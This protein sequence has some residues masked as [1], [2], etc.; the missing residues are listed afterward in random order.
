AAFPGAQYVYIVRNDTVRQAVSLAKAIRSGQWER[1]LSSPASFGSAT[2]VASTTTQNQGDPSPYDR[3]LIEWCYRK[4]HDDMRAWCGAF[5]TAGIEPR[6]IEYE[7]L[8]AGYETVAESLLNYLKLPAVDRQ[9]FAQLDM[10]RQADAVNEEWVDRF[11]RES[12]SL[13]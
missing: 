6:R 9:V 8:D 5:A 1:R 13:E 7:Q 4:L 11:R 2:A 3:G 10:Q 12:P